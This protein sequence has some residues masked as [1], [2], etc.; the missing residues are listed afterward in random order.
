MGADR[1]L[2]PFCQSC[3]M[4]LATAD[5]FGTDAQGFRVNEYCRFCYANGAFTEP[6]ISLQA[7]IDRC[8]AIMA[9]QGVMPLADAKALMTETL[10]KLG[11]WRTA[12]PTGVL[13]I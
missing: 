7:M 10:P 1:P 4:P 8:A 5:D 3:G 9:R 6:E 11:R 12:R 2:G 13:V